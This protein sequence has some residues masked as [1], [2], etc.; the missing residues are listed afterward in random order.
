MT[1]FGLLFKKLYSTQII[2]FALTGLVN[3]FFGYFIYALLIYL[4]VVYSVALLISTVLGVLFN[5]L[6]FGSVVFKIEKEWRIFFKFIFSY[7]CV[8][9]I[10]V[11]LLKLL[12]D[13]LSIDPYSSQL[14]CMIPS[15]SVNWVLLKYWVY[16]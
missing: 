16:I 15:V 2:R 3:T 4:G 10:N 6:T 1:N 12:V 5:Y 8:Y 11:F 9:I 14:L 7:L 13:G